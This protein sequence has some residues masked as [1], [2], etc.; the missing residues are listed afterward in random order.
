MDQDDLSPG[1]AHPALDAQRA[2]R[3][4]ME[5]WARPG[6][7]A[8]VSGVENPPRSLS[9]AGAVVALTLVDHET[10]VWLSPQ[11]AG[12]AQWL[13]FHCGCPLV[14]EPSEA[15]FAFCTSG[16]VQSLTDFNTGT[17]LSPEQGATL[18]LAIDGFE[19]GNL[20]TLTGPGIETDHK[21]WPV[22]ITSGFWAERATMAR[23]Y[24]AG[25]D[26]VLS[27]GSR[28]VCIPRTTQIA[29]E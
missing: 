10:P 27:S 16:E 11:S 28:I 23:L 21:L 3:G 12:A 22:G 13:R 6:L 29:W 7:V 24:P 1:F 25:L 4:L 19:N 17:A 18:I 15:A 26:L 9:S 14:A 5:A 8:E 2:F 20:I